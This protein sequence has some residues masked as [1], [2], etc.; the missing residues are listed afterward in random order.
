MQGFVA[1]CVALVLLLWA[2]C[3][4]SQITPAGS[5]LGRPFSRPSV[6][7][8]VAFAAILACS[9]SLME[10]RFRPNLKRVACRLRSCR[11]SDVSRPAPCTVQT[12]EARRTIISLNY[13]PP[14][15]HGQDAEYCHL[16]VR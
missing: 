6:S 3:D 9:E 11:T 16:I 7:I 15:L 10:R 14:G 5:V 4:T 1:G 2:R 13:S 8:L 12:H